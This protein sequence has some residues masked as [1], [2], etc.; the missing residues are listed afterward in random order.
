[1]ARCLMKIF[2]DR[3]ALVG[4][5][6]G[7]EPI[8]RWTRKEISGVGYWFFPV[9]QRE[10]S[11]KRP[12]VPARAQFFA[13]LRRYRASIQSLGCRAAFIQAP[14]ALMAVSRWRWDSL[15]FWFPGVESNLKVSR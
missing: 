11:A 4:M 9:C 10:L 3:L 1:M 14:E 7:E 8:G 2:G 15:C 6:A 13:G 12:L 5:T